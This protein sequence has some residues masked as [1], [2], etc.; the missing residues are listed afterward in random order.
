MSTIARR[1]SF[2]FALAARRTA[3]FYLRAG[4][5]RLLCLTVVGAAFGVGRVAWW[6]W[7]ALALA[8]LGSWQGWG[9]QRAV[10]R[11]RLP[12]NPLLLWAYNSAVNG[13]GKHTV[14]VAGALEGISCLTLA[15]ASAHAVANS[16]AALVALAFVMA[17]AVSVFSSVFVDNANYNPADKPFFAFEALRRGVGP[18]LVLLAAAMVLPGWSGTSWVTPALVCGLGMLASVRVRETDRA[19]VEAYREARESQR[20]EGRDDVLNQTHGLSNDLDRALAY[21][22]RIKTDRPEVFEY[23]QSAVVRLQ[24][25]TALEHPYFDDVEYPESLSRAVRR[26]ARAY[27]AFDRTDIR[28][29]RL[30][31]ADHRLARILVHD[32]VGN[33]GKA[34]ASRI[35][36]TFEPAGDGVVRLSVEDDAEPFP[37]NAWKASGSSLARIERSLVQRAGSLSLEQSTAMKTVRATWVLEAGGAS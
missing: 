9:L 19:F 13:H 23:I 8:A 31:D 30:S 3:D 35:S 36:M 15:I 6:A 27:G 11:N 26:F 10:L 24:Q 25:L 17:Y 7:I 34:G 28:V 18:I 21:G 2:T 22:A 20:L 5:A 14:N 37:A 4:Q 12:R 29:P 33:A 16:D 32:L 1:N